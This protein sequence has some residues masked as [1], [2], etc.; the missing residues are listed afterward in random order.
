MFQTF[1]LA[2]RLHSMACILQP[3]QQPTRQKQHPCVM[4]CS[5][6]CSAEHSQNHCL[7]CVGT[8]QSQTTLAN[9]LHNSENMQCCAMAQPLMQGWHPADVI[10]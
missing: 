2:G 8:Q 5:S 3:L 4:V 9:N 10:D 7:Q 6:T 1:L